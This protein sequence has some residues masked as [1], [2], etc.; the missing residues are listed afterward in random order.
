MAELE[1]PTAAVIFFKKLHFKRLKR[2]AAVWEKI[3]QVIYLTNNLSLENIE[4]SQSST[5]KNQT[6]QFKKRAKYL[7]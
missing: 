7:D 3:L 2:Q 6:T 1:I 5:I 4:N